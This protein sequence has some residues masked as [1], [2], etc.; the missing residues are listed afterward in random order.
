MKYFKKLVGSRLYLSP[1]NPEDAETYAHWINDLS[2]SVRLGTSREVIGLQR[3]QK[4][5]EDLAKEG[6]NYAIV[7]L[8]GDQLLGNCSLFAIDHVRRVAEVGIFLGDEGQRGQ[9]YGTEALQLICEYGFKIL[10]LN[11][12]MLRV[13][14]FNQ[15][16]IRCY[17]KAGFRVFGRRSR[18]YYVNNDYFDEIYMEL[19]RDDCQTSYLDAKLPRRN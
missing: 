2:V 10:N 15:P 14:E 9:G 13:F 6:Q 19:L 7:Q 8:D 5:L 1:V 3:E 11:N 4:F 17:E 12:I 18:S 16:A